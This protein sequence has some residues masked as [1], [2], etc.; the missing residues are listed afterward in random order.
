MT[1]ADAQES[2]RRSMAGLGEYDCVPPQGRGICPPAKETAGLSPV[3]VRHGFRSSLE[4]SGDADVGEKDDH[5]DR[6]DH[7]AN[8]GGDL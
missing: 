1:L 7:A 3:G 2:A 5:R 8:P 4:V 6:E